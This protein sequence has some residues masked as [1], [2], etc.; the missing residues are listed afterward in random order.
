MQSSRHLLRFLRPYWRWAVLAPLCMALEV[1][2]DLMQ[3]RLL[4]TIIDQGIAHSNM[5]LVVHTCL[6][7]IGLALLGLLA[8]MG[9]GLFAVLAAQSFGADLRGS[10]FRKIQTLSF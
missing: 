7:M 6:W 3:P 2:F 5:T 9:C 4:Q 1:A 10:L 8:G